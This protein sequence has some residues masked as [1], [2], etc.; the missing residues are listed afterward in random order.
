M[1]VTSKFV[2]FLMCFFLPTSRAEKGT[3]LKENEVWV[4]S[5]WTWTSQDMYVRNATCVLWTK[6]DCSDRLHK[7]ICKIDTTT[8]KKIIIRK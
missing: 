5:R 1:T 6:K 3:E 2:A 4:C 7:E 8:N